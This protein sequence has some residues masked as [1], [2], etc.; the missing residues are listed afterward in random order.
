MNNF[1]GLL[2]TVTMDSRLR[3]HDTGFSRQFSVMPTKVG[4]HAGMTT[5][6]QEAIHIYL[7]D[8]NFSALLSCSCESRALIPS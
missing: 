4:I 5:T 3:G 6:C 8:M 2:A 7:Q 1:F